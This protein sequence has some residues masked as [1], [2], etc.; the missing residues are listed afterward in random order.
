MPESRHTQRLSCSSRVGR[1]AEVL[2]VHGQALAFAYVAAIVPARHRP[3]HWDLRHMRRGEVQGERAAALKLD[4]SLRRVPKG[5]V[6]DRSRLVCRS[7]SL[8][9]SSPRPLGSWT[10]PS[11]SQLLH[12]MRWF[13]TH[14]A[15]HTQSRGSMNTGALPTTATVAIKPR[16]RR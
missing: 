6:F 4:H 14:V 9:L 10:G 3:Q 13:R 1:T 11:S 7:T 2:S 5:D 12:P 15:T 16:L 8:F